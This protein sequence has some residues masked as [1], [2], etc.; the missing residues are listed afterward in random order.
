M[1]HLVRSAVARVAAVPRVIRRSGAA[2]AGADSGCRPPNAS[3]PV[4]QDERGHARNRVTTGAVL[5]G[6]VE[7][8]LM[9]F[10]SG[11]KS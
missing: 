8:I 7:S 4:I 6:V 9:L 1:K 3:R 10:E 5:A 2:P 11:I